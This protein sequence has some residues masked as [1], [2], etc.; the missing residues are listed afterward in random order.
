MYL[1]VGDMTIR[2]VL[3]LHV[4]IRGYMYMKVLRILITAFIVCYISCG[5]W[6][7]MKSSAGMLPPNV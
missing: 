5:V 1:I 3:V 6:A 7:A 2:V 4:H